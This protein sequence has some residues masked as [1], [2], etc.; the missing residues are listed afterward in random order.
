MLPAGS[1]RCVGWACC[2]MLLKHKQKSTAL[3]RSMEGRGQ[4]ALPCT[5]QLGARFSEPPADV[6]VTQTEAQVPGRQASGAGVSLKTA[7]IL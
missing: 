5:A 1:Q 6:C 4:G 7:H 3:F 2:L